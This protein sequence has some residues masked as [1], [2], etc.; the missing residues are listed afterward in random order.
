MFAFLYSIL[1]MLFYP[2][3]I[4]LILLVASAVTLRQRPNLS[5][6]CFW[7]AIATILVC[8][9][10]WLVGSLT[11]HLERKHLA[12][13]PVP[14]A[15]AILVLSGGIWA[16]RPP[17][18]TVEI[19][20]AG[21]RLLYGGYLYRQKKAPALICT[22]GVATGGLTLRP[23]ADDMSELLQILGVPPEAV[24]TE[25]ESGNTR[26]HAR[27]LVP[28]F[29]K[30]GDKRVLLV[31]SALHMPRSLG[32]FRKACPSIEFIP[33]PTDFRVTD[34]VPHP[35]H[36]KLPGLIPTPSSL[37]AFCEVT[38]EYLGMAYYR[39]RGWM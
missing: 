12:P 24:I 17:R 37:Q 32:V 27:N 21:D 36:R 18:P 15:D 23:I 13:V 19:G 38:H 20:E 9:N 28:I 2:T 33:A 30:R 26:E 4:A 3:S 25:G 34:P 1:R 8:G 35:W 5:R 11:S 29:A 22:G 16:K 7:L 14:D 39:L 31:T 10:G 6:R